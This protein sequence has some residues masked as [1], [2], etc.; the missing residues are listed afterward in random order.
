MSDIKITVHTTAGDIDA[1]LYGSKAPLT[2]ANFLNLARRGYYDG[3]A[4]HRVIEDFMLQGGDPTGT[5][6]GGPGYKFADEFHRTPLNTPPGVFSM[7]NAGPGTNGSQFFITHLRHP[8]LDGRHSVFG[9]VTNGLDVGRNNR[10][11]HKRRQDHLHHHPRRHHGA[12]RIP[13]GQYRTL[14]LDPGS[15]IPRA[16]G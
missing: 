15:L 1:T 6:R 3:V 16:A 13:K 7:A 5:G 12:I 2:C 14:E 9:Q 10:S 11:E 8:F 4:F